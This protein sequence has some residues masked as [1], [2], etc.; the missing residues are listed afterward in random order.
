MKYNYAD[1]PFVRAL[2]RKYEYEKDEAIATLN[3]YFVNPAGISEHS[4]FVE[5]MDKWVSKLAAAD[6][7]LKVLV[8]T[9]VNVPQPAAPGAP[10]ATEES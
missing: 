6:E 3:V 1:S 9:F 4:D 2:I 8:S 5:E 7:N 10:E